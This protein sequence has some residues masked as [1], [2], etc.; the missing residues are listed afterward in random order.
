MTP[1]GPAPQPLELKRALGN[2]GH[3]PLPDKR[4]T[5]ALE[6]IAPKPPRSLGLGPAGRRTWSHVAELSWVSTSDAAALVTLC[7]TADL[8]ESL[9]AD[10]AERGPAFEARGRWYI[11]PSVRSLLDA[12]KQLWNMLGAFGLT[13]ADRAR[14]GIAEVKAQSKLEELQARRAARSGG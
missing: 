1:R 9:A 12:R 7:Q 10:V 4:S 11:N 5:V 3:R 6:R 2:P 8:V 13:P 14:Q